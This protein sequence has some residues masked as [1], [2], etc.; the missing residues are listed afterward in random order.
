VQN[1]IRTLGRLAAKTFRRLSV[2][3]EGLLPLIGVR[4]LPSGLARNYELLF[5]STNQWSTCITSV[6]A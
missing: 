5:V 2:K 1:A 4:P 6:R 3:L